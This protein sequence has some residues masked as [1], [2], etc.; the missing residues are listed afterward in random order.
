MRCTVSN[1]EDSHRTFC[2]PLI[3]FRKGNIDSRQT[4]LQGTQILMH[5]YQLIF[6]LNS[7]ILTRG[8]FIFFYF[9]MDV[10]VVVLEKISISRYRFFCKRN[11]IAEIK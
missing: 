8:F 1:K 2:Q 7:D 9:L 10:V 6:Q 4:Q 11:K 5:N 3:A